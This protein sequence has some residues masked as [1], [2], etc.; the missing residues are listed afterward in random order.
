MPGSTE[1]FY[2]PGWTHEQAAR[3]WEALPLLDE[4]IA[5]AVGEAPTHRLHWISAA[6]ALA[7]LVLGLLDLLP[8]VPW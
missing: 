6:I 4:P 8:A 5:A 7:L 1:T 3:F 2:R